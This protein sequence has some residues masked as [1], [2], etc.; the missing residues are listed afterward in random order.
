MNKMCTLRGL[1]APEQGKHCA[2]GGTR[3]GRQPLKIRH[4]PENLPNRADSDVGTTESE[5]QG[6]DTV[7]TLFC[8][9]FEPQP[10]QV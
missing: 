3:T 9:N 6:V 4:S 5:A 10:M 7:H 2:R 8:E 1:K